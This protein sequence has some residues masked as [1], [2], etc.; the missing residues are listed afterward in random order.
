MLFPA[1]ISMSDQRYFSLVNCESTLKYRWSEVENETKSD[2]GFPTLTNVDAT[3]VPDV[4]T[5][6]KRR[7][8]TSKQPCTTL[9]QYWYNVV[10]TLWKVVSTL[11]NVVLMLFKRRALTLY[12]RCAKLFKATLNP[13]EVVMIMDF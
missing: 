11:Y 7:C 2:V 8:T 5:T 3:L 1:N 13:I 4:E 10:S 6:S 12:P 9:I